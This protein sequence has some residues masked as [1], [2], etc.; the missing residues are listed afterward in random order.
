MGI[1]QRY[2]ELWCVTLQ[3]VPGQWKHVTVQ[4]HCTANNRI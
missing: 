1:V 4:K 2:G 3:I